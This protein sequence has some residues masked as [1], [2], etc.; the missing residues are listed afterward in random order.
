MLFEGYEGGKAAAMAK[1]RAAMESDPKRIA[2]K[3]QKQ[4]AE[5]KKRLEDIKGDEGEGD[6][7]GDDDVVEVDSGGDEEA[8]LMDSMLDKIGEGK[9]R[10]EAAEDRKKLLTGAFVDDDDID[11]DLLARAG[12]KGSEDAEKVSGRSRLVTRKAMSWEVAS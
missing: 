11:D 2:K 6:G 7:A 1:R 10:E 5:M 12:Y 9:S 3:K 4:L 8:E